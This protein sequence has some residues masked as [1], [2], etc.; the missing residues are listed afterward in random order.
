MDEII[1]I[2]A[3]AITRIVDEAWKGV[4]DS[5]CGKILKTQPDGS[6]IIN[7]LPYHTFLTVLQS[8]L[9]KNITTEM[10]EPP[11]SWRGGIDDPFHPREVQR[12]S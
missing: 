10:K 11:E 1:I 4:E 2:S 9:P 6:V 3:K 12:Q 8:V 7:N 5:K